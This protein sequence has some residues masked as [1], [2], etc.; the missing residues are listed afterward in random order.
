MS[1]QHLS[2]PFLL[3]FRENFMLYHI[4]NSN[5]I[6]GNTLTFEETIRVIK[7]GIVAANKPIKD[8]LDV[9]GL[10][11]AFNYM[12][13]IAENK[14]PLCEKVIKKLHSLVLINDAVNKGIYR[15]LPVTVIG[16]FHLPPAAYLVPKQIKSLLADYEK[17][18]LDK[19]ILEAITMFHLH[20]LHIH[21]FLIGNGRT[22]RLIINLEL[23]KNGFL[24]IDIPFEDRRT[25]YNC[26]NK[27]YSNGELIH[28]EL[29]KLLKDYEELELHKYISFYKK[30]QRNRFSK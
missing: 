3:S 2:E 26:L 19:H 21:P 23:I 20:F 16:A 5:A 6:N 24:P 12:L 15:N 22:G 29:L 25:Y 11:D 18:K 8:H 28:N 10:F 27:F 1:L 7:D 13:S 9:I 14:K 30:L 17:M 4:Y